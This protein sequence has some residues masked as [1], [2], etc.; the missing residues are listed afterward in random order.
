M[1]SFDGWLAAM[2]VADVQRQIAEIEDKMADL[3][4]RADVLRLLVAQRNEHVHA[5]SPPSASA[6]PLTADWPNLVLAHGRVGRRSSPERANILRILGQRPDGA[7]IQAI[8]DALGK[9][10]NP[11]STNLSRMTQAGMIERIG[12]GLYRLPPGP[13]TETPPLSVN[14]VERSG[15]DEE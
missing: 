7:S 11:V 15:S 6:V 2:P 5:A 10:V 1:D 9:A 12:T 13:P 14:G 4:R 8:A 3:A